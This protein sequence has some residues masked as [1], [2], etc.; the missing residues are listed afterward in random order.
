MTLG[1]LNANFNQ[2]PRLFPIEPLSLLF[3]RLAVVSV[4]GEGWRKGEMNDILTLRELVRSR[5]VHSSLLKS[6]PTACKVSAQVSHER[7]HC[8]RKRPVLSLIPGRPSDFVENSAG[9]PGYPSLRD[10]P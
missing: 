6:Q 4:S 5:E 10:T 9:H 7:S 8:W 3:R 1:L 2:F